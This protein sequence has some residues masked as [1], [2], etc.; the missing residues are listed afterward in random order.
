MLVKAVIASVA[1]A[2]VMATVNSA[3]AETSLTP[4]NSSIGKIGRAHV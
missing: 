4:I 3:F 2:I 1:F